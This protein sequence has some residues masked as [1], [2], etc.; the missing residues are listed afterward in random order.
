MASA[1]V[2]QFVDTSVEPTVRGFLHKSEQA[3]PPALVLTHG[4][5]ADCQ[6]KLLVNLAQ[7]FAEAGFLVLRCNLPFR[8]QRFH[9][10]PHPGDAEHDRLG[11]KRALELI[12]QR[13]SGPVFLG[14]HSYGGRQ[15]SMLAAAEPGLVEGLLLLSYPLHPPRR[16]ERLRTAHFPRL[17]TPVLFVHGSRDPFASSQELG[18]A[19]TLIPGRHAVLEIDGAGHE[20]LSR[21]TEATLP[22]QTAET[23]QQFVAE[24]P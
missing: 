12:R 22:I 4:A 5:G 11:L 13:T 17:A 1:S 23:F 14:G 21:K 7:T 10:P 20:L 6:S 2:V 18:S 15:G 24:R 3:D 8:Q 16:P 9:G 19:L